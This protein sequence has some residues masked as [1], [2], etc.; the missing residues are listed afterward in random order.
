MA[1]GVLLVLQ[2]ALQGRSLLRA[3]IL[4]AASS[5]HQ[6]PVRGVPRGTRGLPVRG[7]RGR[8]SLRCLTRIRLPRLT[9]SPGGREVQLALRSIALRQP[10]SRV[11]CPPRAVCSRDGPSSVG[12]TARH[13]GTLHRSPRTS[14][15]VKAGDGTAVRRG[16]FIHAQFVFPSPDAVPER[17]PLL[18]PHVRLATW[19][20]S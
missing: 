2:Q 18:V 6:V 20:S 15:S 14:A 10:S 12:G 13:Y 8:W 11:T 3:W 17:A 4:A 9:F 16:V 5:P 7:V 1:A 19:V